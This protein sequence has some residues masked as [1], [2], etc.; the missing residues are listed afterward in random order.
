M[1]N[2]TLKKS[3]MM[4]DQDEEEE[5]RHAREIARKKQANLLEEFQAARLEF[6]V[7]YKE[8]VK[9]AIDWSDSSVAIMFACWVNGF[10]E[11][12]WTPKETLVLARGKNINT[13]RKR[14]E[15]AVERRKRE[16]GAV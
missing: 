16:A 4:L 1:K 6:A 14:E 11:K 15:V 5:K 8:T 13:R 7:W 9:I 2:S 10:G 12:D 3:N